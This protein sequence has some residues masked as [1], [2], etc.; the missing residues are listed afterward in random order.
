MTA[1]APFLA[2]FNWLADPKNRQLLGFGLVLLLI[3]MLMGTCSRI[4]AL[5]G[6][7]EQAHQETQRVANNWQA[8]Q[9]SVTMLKGE[10]GE[11]IGQISGY[12]LTIDELNRDYADMKAKWQFEK[13]KPPVVI[14]ETV[15]VFKDSLIM[16]NVEL[17]GDSVIKVGDTTQFSQDNF[18]I[19]RGRIPYEIDTTRHLLVPGKGIF[20]LEQAMKLNTLLTRDKGTGKIQIQVSTDYPGVRFSQIQGAVIQDDEENRKVLKQ[21]RKQWGLSISA[22]YGVMLNMVNVNRIGLAHGPYAGFGIHY[23]PKWA[24]WGK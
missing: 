6:E 12:V 10:N 5:E 8:S 15:T 22:G 21:S 18:R 2:I 9:D 7:V 17:D 4:S 1:L 24:Q 13:N 20:E 11:M 16:V 19:I 14:I 23:T 3:F